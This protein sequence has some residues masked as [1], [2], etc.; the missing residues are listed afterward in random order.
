MTGALV[1]TLVFVLLRLRLLGLDGR[2][3]VELDSTTRGTRFRQGKESQGG[4]CTRDIQVLRCDP[5]EYSYSED[6][7]PA[8]GPTS[9]SEVTGVF[10]GLWLF[11][12]EVD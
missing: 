4:Q 6:A 1:L 11:D 3:W 2:G 8:E 5:S 12:G 10:Q 9:G 7:P